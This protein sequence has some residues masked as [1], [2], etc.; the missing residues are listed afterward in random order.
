[1]AYI[2]SVE[3]PYRWTHFDPLTGCYSLQSWHD[4]TH[5][6]PDAP[7]LPVQK[8]YAF[9]PPHDT[10]YT[11]ERAS[12]HSMFLQGDCLEHSQTLRYMSPGATQAS[13]LSEASYSDESAYSLDTKNHSIRYSTSPANSHTQHTLKLIDDPNAQHMPW[14]AQTQH[15]VLQWHVQT[16]APNVLPTQ[17]A[18][19]LKDEEFEHEDSKDVSFVSD[20]EVVS[21]PRSPVGM[22]QPEEVEF[23]EPTTDSVTSPGTLSQAKKSVKEYRGEDDMDEDEHEDPVPIDNHSDS[24]YQ[25]RPRK[26]K[27]TRNTV[28]KNAYSPK[29]KRKS[30][31]HLAQGNYRV[32][33]RAN[34]ATATA[35][36]CHSRQLSKSKQARKGPIFAKTLSSTTTRP[37]NKADRTF[38]CT[39]HHFGC[40]SEFPNKNEWKRHVACQHLQL[41]Y[42]R[43]DLD[44]CNPDNQ[45]LAPGN[46]RQSLKSL[47]KRIKSE[48][49]DQ[50]P[51]DADQEV[52]VI[53]NDFNRKDLFTQH[54]RRMHGPSRNPALCTATNKKGTCVASKE[55]AA[56]FERQLDA[57][58]RRC[59]SIRRRAP[60]RST[61]GFCLQV[62]DAAYYT[63]AVSGGAAM[64]GEV[65]QGPEEKA[66]EE[67]M[68]HVGRHYEKDVGARK[69][70]EDVDED[71][72]E[73][74]LAT[75]VLYRLPDG[76]PWLVSA[77]APCGEG[78]ERAVKDEDD[79]GNGNVKRARRQPS[80]TVVVRKWSPAAVKEEDDS[81]MDA[82]GED[83]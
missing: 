47:N 14:Q 74:G 36:T 3:E 81:D 2:H 59:W 7:F 68:E 51:T 61:C 31:T 76:R 10:L 13:S 53:Y 16:V 23:S 5:T 34:S 25:A 15:T 19:Y 1:M 66:W 6:P 41:G 67:R 32:H 12:M 42:Y 50:E 33:K 9:Q 4:G 55:D 80:R 71:L 37:T 48:S 49:P 22:P 26:R 45:A 82:D 65:E 39:F 83:E 63:H 60:A 11:F 70:G 72:V 29:H 18:M 56:S 17:P 24:S 8:S 43:C 75:G 46:R 28:A 38:P 44:G 64:N 58:R 30:S 62:F 57:I 21:H 79:R 69:E 40:P 54:A 20:D 78:E 77:D 27:N 35:S 73:W 52:L